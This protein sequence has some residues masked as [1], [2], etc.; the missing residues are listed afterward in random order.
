MHTSPHH[1]QKENPGIDE[2]MPVEDARR[3][4][5]AWIIA[6]LPAAALFAVPPSV[7][8]APLISL[9]VI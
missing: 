8:V 5:A 9:T 6:A 1:S 4:A 2:L 3:H 7:K